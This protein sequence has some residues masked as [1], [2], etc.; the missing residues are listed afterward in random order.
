MELI[1][2]CTTADRES[3]RARER[4]RGFNGV[5]KNPCV[6]RVERREQSRAMR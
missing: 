4:E 2:N 1:E 5:I 6:G 3:E